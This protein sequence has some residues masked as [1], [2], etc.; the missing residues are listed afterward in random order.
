VCFRLDRNT[1][2]NCTNAASA[3]NWLVAQSMWC[4]YFRRGVW[5]MDASFSERWLGFRSLSD[6]LGSRGELVDHH[7]SSTARMVWLRTDS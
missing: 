2:A 1:S 7:E 3:A 6:F 4:S 5:R